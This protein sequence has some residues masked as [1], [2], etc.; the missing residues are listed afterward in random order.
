MTLANEG[1]L[2][3]IF[4]GEDEKHD[5]RPLYEWIVK[6]ARSEGLAGATVLRGMMGFGGG[7]R[8]I[9]SF[10]I[11]RLAEQLPVVV[12]IVDTRDKLHAFLDHIDSQI[13]G[14][15]ATLEPVDVRFYRTH[16][17]T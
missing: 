7:S 15:L 2:L 9:H 5:G 6:Q 8:A 10:K 14:G 17:H 3:R 13:R 16:S 11:E 4:V 1:C 12:E